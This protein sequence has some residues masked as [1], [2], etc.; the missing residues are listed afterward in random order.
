MRRMLMPVWG[1][2]GPKIQIKILS[3]T[4][5]WGSGGQAPCSASWS[6]HRGRARLRAPR[7]RSGCSRSPECGTRFTIM[8]IITSSILWRKEKKTLRPTPTTQRIT[9]SLLHTR[10]SLRSASAALQLWGLTW[11]KLIRNSNL[12]RSVKASRSKLRSLRHLIP[13]MRLVLWNESTSFNWTLKSFLVRWSS[14]LASTRHS[15]NVVRYWLRPREGSQSLPIHSWFMSPY[16]R[17]V[18]NKFW[19][20]FNQQSSS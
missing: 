16:A 19:S 9:L 5:V 17:V 1:S 14:I 15:M 2:G 6:S 8:A 12:R 3:W 10:T 11:V 4:P 7:T 20:V 13:N 18:L